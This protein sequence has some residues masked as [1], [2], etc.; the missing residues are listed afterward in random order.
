M[1][2][3]FSFKCDLGYILN[4][5]LDAAPNYILGLYVI[6]KCHTFRA[7]IPFLFFAVAHTS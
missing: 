5:L 4:Y 7:C 6:P 2:F 1:Q 3:F